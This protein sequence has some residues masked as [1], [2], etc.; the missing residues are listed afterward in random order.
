MKATRGRKWG[1]SMRMVTRRR[2]IIFWILAGLF[3]LG[4]GILAATPPLVMGDMINLH[5]DFKTT[6]DAEDFGL[7]VSELTLRTVDGYG[8]SAFEVEA[9]D[10]KA[11][12]IFISGIH[13]P[14]VTAFFGHARM[15][16]EHGY[17]SVLYDMRAHGKSEGDVITL[18]YLETHDTQAVVDY[19]RSKGAYQDL[20]IIVYGLSMGGTVAINS[21]GQIPEIAGL[22]SMSA[23]SSWEDVFQ[24]NML[25]MG[26]PELLTK[27][28]KPFVKLYTVLKFG[29]KTSN[30]YPAKQIANLGSRPALLIHSLGD[31][32]VPYGN[33]ARIVEQAPSQVE[34]WTRPGDEH[35]IIP[36]F[37]HPEND[38]EYAGGVLEFFE[39]NFGS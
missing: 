10:P 28:Q 15:F 36:D 30:I 5:V 27:V 20:P 26:F 6:Y 22:V 25:A 32:Q 24:E 34:T 38:A 11:V 8:I 4:V 2:R 23:Y 18:G 16:R 31:T 12:I 17:A 21:I 29:W 13:N 1:L 35:M 19:I 9:D 39:R 37:L 14:S 3:L 33:L 7:E